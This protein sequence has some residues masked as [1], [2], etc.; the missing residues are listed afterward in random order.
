MKVIISAG[1]T[2]GHIF[3]AIAVADELRRR[4]PSVQILF[5]GAKGKMEMERV[6]KAG[7]AIEGLWISGF[8]RRLTWQNLMFPFKVLSSMWKA[9]R[10]IGDFQPDVVV[11]FGGFASGPTLRVAA[12]KGI[13]TVLQ[14]Q[15]SY[16]G[17]TN[18]LLAE[19]AMKI[20]VA[21]PNM[22]RF[23]PKNKVV[24]TG[25]PVRSDIL[26]LHAKKLEGIKH[27]NLNPNRK[28][29]VIIGGSLG[30][31]TL[32]RAMEA[33]VDL[34]AQN[35]DVQIL[36]QCG[37]LYEVDF[38]DGKA[39]NLPNVQMKTFIDRMDLVY[40]AADVIIARAGALTISELCLAGV[41]SVLVPS[42]NVAEDHQTQNAMSLV[43]EKAAILVKDVH[44][45]E[46]MIE[47][48]LQILRNDLLQSDLK[49]NILRLGR[50]YACK[51]IAD[52]IIHAAQPM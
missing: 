46:E 19:K 39:A 14:E 1:G 37:K 5:V 22:E 33:S 21:Y 25:N 8:Q 13:P 12:S 32:N 38:K 45:Q 47:K 28:T 40:A 52:E 3:P 11:G 24:L 23:F 51:D 41:P 9:R 26:N 48:A 16:A 20:C 18:K 27:F 10:I 31:R 35:Q 6:P 36:W 2:G 29:I 15:N 4:D 43:N 17:V 34:I 44:A 49:T 7:Y 30:A 42:P 50:P